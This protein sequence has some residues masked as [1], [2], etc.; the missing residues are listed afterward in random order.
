MV[1]LPK[2]ISFVPTRWKTKL[3]IKP[4]KLGM[5]HYSLCMC[6][7]AHIRTYIHIWQNRYNFSYIVKV[8]IGCLHR[9]SKEAVL[10]PNIKDLYEQ[11][12]GSLCSKIVA[13]KYHIFLIKF[14]HIFANHKT[15][16]FFN[17]RINET[18][19]QGWM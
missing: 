18:L 9:V 16:K 4:K 2:T 8:Y 7:W 12:I 19:D 11:S 15:H 17:N 6:V 3:K 1:Y 13:Y 10:N 14:D 5:I